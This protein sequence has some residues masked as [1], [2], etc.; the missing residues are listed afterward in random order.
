MKVSKYVKKLGSSTSWLRAWALEPDRTG[1][2]SQFYYES[3]YVASSYL[4][5]SLSSFNDNE[6][7]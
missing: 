7:L 6:G 4:V 3:D 1:F 5:N 2:K